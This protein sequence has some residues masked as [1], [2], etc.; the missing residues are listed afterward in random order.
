[1]LKVVDSD[2]F[3]KEIK[4]LYDTAFPREERYLDFE[5]TVKQMEA[6]DFGK[7]R[8]E[9][10]AFGEDTGE[11]AGFVGFVMVL[12][13][14]DIVHLYYFAIQEKLRG[15]KYGE[16]AL[17]LIR[18]RYR[19]RNIWLSVEL[20]DENADNQQQRLRRKQFYYRNGFRDTDVSGEKNGC[21][22]QMMSTDGTVDSDIL[23]QLDKLINKMITEGRKLQ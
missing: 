5:P 6:A 7:R 3:M 12:F 1:M 15:R 9:L 10:L 11:T 2:S 20:P 22:L 4:E 13:C 17:N 21:M 23:I 18:E 16:Q 14:G 19:D 8:G